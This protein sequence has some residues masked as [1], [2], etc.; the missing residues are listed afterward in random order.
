MQA[1]EASV[2][3]AKL[4]EFSIGWWPEIRIVYDLVYHFKTDNYPVRRLHDYTYVL[5]PRLS[6]LI[7]IR[8]HFSQCYYYFSSCAV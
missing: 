6:V 1:A 3:S 8:I 5:S 2:G 7:T 4:P